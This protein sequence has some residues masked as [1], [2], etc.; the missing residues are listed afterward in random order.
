MAKALEDVRILDLTQFEAGTTCTVLLAF[1]G[2]D[3]IKVENPATGDL[4]R[5]S[6]SERGHEKID[7]YYFLF[8]NA[9]KKSVTL[10]LK[11][12]R[13]KQIFKEMVKK[14]DIVV[15]NFSVGT[16]EKLGLSYDVLKEINPAIIYA[17]ITGFGTY[18]PYKDYPCFDIV[19]QAAGGLMGV[20]GFPE[21]PP[22]KVGTGVGDSIGAINL[23]V[24]ILGALYQ[25]EKTGR[26]QAVEV[27]MQDCI[28]ST[29]R[30]IFNFFYASGCKP[31]ERMGN[32]AGG[33]LAPWNSYKALDGYVVIG[34]LT[35]PLWENLLRAINQED[36]IS[37][38]RFSD[39][40]TRGLNSDAVDTLIEE[41][42]CK[43]NKMEAMNYLAEKGVPCGA[44]LDLQE[45]LD[46]PHLKKRDMLAEIDHPTRGK[47][48]I[49]GSPI[50]LSES[51]QQ[52]E[53]APLLG[54]HNE[55]IYSSLLNLSK[56]EIGQLKEEKVI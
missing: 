35:N 47:L 37:D 17:S 51:E 46:N 52:I 27:S 14:A 16:M 18:G 45:L 11:K 49:L 55:K 24:G 44:V 19:A 53:P 36:S 25:R 30:P 1:L 13:G 31:V 7:S 29:L 10:N 39:P 50:K 48:S 9:N 23:A 43:K 4:G 12:E 5:F 41:W 21:N 28:F 15:N 3:V 38:P 56:K 20:T 26:G 8:L 6:F 42:T 32:S 34:I 54:E 22:T 40:L 33:V 2:A